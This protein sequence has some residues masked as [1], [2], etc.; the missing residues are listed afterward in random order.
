M[1]SF[2]DIYK[3]N[4]AVFK[5]LNSPSKI[6]DFINK[7]PVNF[8]PEGKTCNSPL[9]VLKNNK[10]HCM[11]GAVLA[12]ACFWYNGK[13]PLLLDLKTYKDD[14]HVVALFKE[15]GRWGA[16]SKT[17]HAVLRYRDPIFKTVRELALSYFNEYFLTSSGAK[18]MRS[19]SVTF[20]LLQ[21]DDDWLVSEKDI[22]RI[23]EELDDSRHF[24]IFP[25]GTR[26]RPADP[27]EIEAGKI[28][29]WKR[30]YSR[31]RK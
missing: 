4:F 6:Q 16:V 13:P 24:K 28:T 14:D 17:N 12:A 3:K 25:S 10:A 7:I 11:E 5:K 19:Y 29:E 26:L 31:L 21:Y 30:K 2:P 22:W 23:P 1:L 15:N 8:E 18:T 9:T 27:V 20:S